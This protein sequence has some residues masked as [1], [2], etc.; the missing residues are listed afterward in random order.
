MT[1]FKPAGGQGAM[2]QKPAKDNASVNEPADVRGYSL[3]DD[4][5]GDEPPH[6]PMPPV[7]PIPG[8]ASITGWPDPS[9]P[10]IDPATQAA[11]LR[12]KQ[13]TPETPEQP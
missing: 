4:D 2:W 5:L 8:A 9:P 1:E 11:W 3:D 10:V 12:L 7:L 13:E 6:V